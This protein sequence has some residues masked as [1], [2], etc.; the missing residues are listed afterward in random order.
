MRHAPPPP[1]LRPPVAALR[2]LGLGAASYRTAALDDRALEGTLA[3]ARAPLEVRAAAAVALGA[4][5]GGA[6]RLRVAADEVADARLRR[7]TLRVAESDLDP[8]ELQ[9]ELESAERQSRARR[10][11]RGRRD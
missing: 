3:D 9:A 11:R 1:P 7:I 6:R 2:E 10:G 8:A 4:K 5:G